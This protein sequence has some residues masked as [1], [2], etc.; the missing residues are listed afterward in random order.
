MQTSRMG[1]TAQSGFIALLCTLF[2]RW[3]G[4]FESSL[5][6]FKSCIYVAFSRHRIIAK[7]CRLT[8]FDL[9]DRTWRL[10]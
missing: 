6:R 2:R 9:D 7:N 8:R 3:P 10:N 5:D 4:Q 1:S